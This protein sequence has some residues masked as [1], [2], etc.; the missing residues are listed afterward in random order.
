M[1]DLFWR[2]LCDFL[3]VGRQVWPAHLDLQGC[4]CVRQVLI[5]AQSI[6]EF[7]L[8]EFLDPFE[9]PPGNQL[10]LQSVNLFNECLLQLLTGFQ[11]GLTSVLSGKA[12][13]FECI[14][15]VGRATQN[16]HAA[17]TVIGIVGPCLHRKTIVDDVLSHA[18]APA[19]AQDHGHGV[20]G[21]EIVSS[22]M[23]AME[24][25]S[26]KGCAGPFQKPDTLTRAL[27][28]RL[29]GDL[30]GCKL[31]RGIPLEIRLCELLGLLEPHVTHQ[32]ADRIRRV[33]VLL[34]KCGS[35]SGGVLFHVGFPAN[36][37]IVI[38]VRRI[39]RSVQIKPSRAVWVVHVTVGPLAL[40]YFLF[41][42]KPAPGGLKQ[43]FAHDGKPLLQHIRR[44]RHGELGLVLACEGVD[45]YGAVPAKLR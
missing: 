28:R 4:Q 33:V 9:L 44:H 25:D 13:L 19:V 42:I 24:T 6:Q 18:G 12:W 1:P 10:G 35:I 43:L 30:L 31:A 34:V 26:H 27:L 41:N 21:V 5:A 20:E 22:H 23:G 16:D 39:G 40:H 29:F 32:H 7:A 45:T 36:G 3:Q 2:D 17:V 15:F 37:W 11:V 14:R 8:D 38:G